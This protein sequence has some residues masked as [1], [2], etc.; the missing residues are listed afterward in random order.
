MWPLYSR[1][2]SVLSSFSPNFPK[3]DSS[4]P[5]A[6]TQPLV[7]KP[8]GTRWRRVSSKKQLGEFILT[9][10]WITG[11]RYSAGEPSCPFNLLWMYVRRHV[12]TLCPTREHVQCGRFY[13]PW[14]EVPDMLRIKIKKLC[15]KAFTALRLFNDAWPVDRIATTIINTLVDNERT[16][17]ITALVRGGR[18]AS[19][20]RLHYNELWASERRRR[21]SVV[22]F[23]RVE[24]PDV[25]VP[26]GTLFTTITYACANITRSF[27]V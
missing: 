4:S 1:N 10:A 18:T 22:Q 2:A 19:E 13:V 7:A 3:M 16:R 15:I 9:L 27:G 14:L 5:T 20:A 23:E 25:E 21:L 24:T 8:R 17:N 12:L 11:L 26:L 6:P